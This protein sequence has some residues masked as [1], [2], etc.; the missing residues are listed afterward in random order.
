MDKKKEDK[1][2]ILCVIPS[3]PEELSFKAIQSVLKQTIPVESVM[4]L[5]KRVKGKTTA[6]KV[7]KL[8]NDGLSHVRIEDFDYLL[9]V[10][11]DTVIPPNFLEENL[12]DNPDLCGEAGYGM[13][14]KTSTFKKVMNG[15]FH[16][17][18]DDSYISYKFL[19]K[20]YKVTKWKVKPI[21]LGDANFKRVLKSKIDRGL[22]MYK[23]G[24]EPFHVILSI[25]W[26][27]RNIFAIFGYFLGFLKREPK[28]DVSSFVWRR[29]IRR[30]LRFTRISKHA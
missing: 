17:E 10:D 7:S 11:G 6:E 26:S 3:L 24:Y 18:S 23:I 25:R 22:L 9:R 21:P 16:P 12:K 2:K 8:L 14:I 4:I 27:L 15:K 19:M 1:V 13:I 5:S 20:G 28:F 30:L 29:Q